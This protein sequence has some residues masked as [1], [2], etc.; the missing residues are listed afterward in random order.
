[1]RVMRCTFCGYMIKTT[2]DIGSMYCGPHKLSDGVYL[3][4]QQMSEVDLSAL[5]HRLAQ[6]K[7]EPRP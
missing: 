7:R 2:R 5:K 3:P 1:M 6:R 4:A